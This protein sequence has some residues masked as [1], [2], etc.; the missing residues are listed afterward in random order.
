[1]Q[2]KKSFNYQ[3]PFLTH[4]ITAS[5]KVLFLHKKNNYTQT[6]KPVPD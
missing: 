6:F 1:M 2:V 4:L 3:N 5:Y